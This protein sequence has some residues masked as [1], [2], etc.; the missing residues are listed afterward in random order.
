MADAALRELER[1]YAAGDVGVLDRLESETRR[2][3]LSHPAVEKAK[4]EAM[5]RL[6]R[7][8]WECRV[9]EFIRAVHELQERIFN[10]TQLSSGPVFFPPDVFRQLQDA[11]D[12]AGRWDLRQPLERASTGGFTITTNATEALRQAIEDLQLTFSYNSLPWA[13]T[14]R[15]LDQLEQK[16]RSTAPFRRP[17]KRLGRG[18]PPKRRWGR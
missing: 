16:A 3:A 15:T 4:Q 8:V 9:P 12:Q 18:R 14:R 5:G 2:S 17:P 1:R 6:L 7:V 10:A 11:A 13:R